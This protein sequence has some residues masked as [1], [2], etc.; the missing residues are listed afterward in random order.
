MFWIYVSF[1]K[2]KKSILRSRLVVCKRS[3]TN[4]TITY[5][6]NFYISIR[7]FSAAA[8]NWRLKFNFCSILENTY[9]NFDNFSKKTCKREVLKRKREGGID[10]FKN[11]L[12]PANGK[13]ESLVQ[14]CVNLAFIRSS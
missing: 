6:L 4:I 3:A 8:T 13:L 14:F 1:L 7:V 5:I 2:N 10:P 11:E 12:F 9:N